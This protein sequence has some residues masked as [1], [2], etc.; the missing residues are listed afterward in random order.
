MQATRRITPW[1]GDDRGW[2]CRRRGRRRAPHS[3]GAFGVPAI[4][5]RRDVPLVGDVD[6]HAGQ[7]LERVHRLGAR[8]RAVGLVG[9]V[10]DRQ[11]LSSLV[12]FPK[13]RG[14]KSSSYR[15]RFN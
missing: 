8:R 2:H 13:G 12:L 9:P 4:V 11:P 14:T 10:G 1:R 6:Q 7:E 5:P 15:S 3:A